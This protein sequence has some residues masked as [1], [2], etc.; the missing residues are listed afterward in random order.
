MARHSKQR[1]KQGSKAESNAAGAQP[2]PDDSPRDPLRAYP[3]DPPQP[4][5]ALLILAAVLF[6]TWFCYLA[7]IALWS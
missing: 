2:A 1:G 7:Y 5:L 6:G 3:A 4:N